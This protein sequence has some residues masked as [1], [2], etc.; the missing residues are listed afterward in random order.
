MVLSC[1]S[2]L[3]DA[4]MH[5]M[6]QEPLQEQNLVDYKGLPAGGFHASAGCTIVWQDGP[7]GRDESRIEPNGA[8]VETVIGAAVSRLLWYQDTAMGRFACPENAQAIAKLEEALA[9]LNRRTAR[10]EAA[11][12]EG[13]HAEEPRDAK[14]C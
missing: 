8:F 1:L 9:I 11:N 12:I 13:T 5:T 4:N 3:F 10:R 2:V 6:K 14:G 7:L